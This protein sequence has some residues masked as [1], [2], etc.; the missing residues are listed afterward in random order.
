MLQIGGFAS[1]VG[2]NVKLV[3]ESHCLQHAANNN[4]LKARSRHKGFGRLTAAPLINMVM[5]LLHTT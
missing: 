2:T 5:N 1:F 4:L 3:I